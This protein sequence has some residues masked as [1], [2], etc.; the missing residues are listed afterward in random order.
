MRRR[1]KEPMNIKIKASD[2][3]RN[4]MSGHGFTVSIFEAMVD[5]T[6]HRMLAVDFGETA[7]EATGFVACAVLDLDMT[8][9]EDI[10]FAMGNS[11]RGDHFH[12]ELRKVTR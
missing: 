12:K 6:R 4:G 11:W 10:T 5:G 9:V 2:Y 1:K 8:A 3:H 7:D